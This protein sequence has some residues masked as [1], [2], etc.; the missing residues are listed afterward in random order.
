MKIG[1]VAEGPADVAVISNIL[2]GKLGIEGKDILPI[3]P[4]LS[5]DETDLH[6]RREETFSNWELVKRECVERARIE[7]FLVPFEDERLVVV[8]IDTAEA[9]LRGY[10]VEKPRDRD[11][12][13]AG[14]LRRRVVEAIDR[15]L[16]GRFAG[17]VRHAVAVEETDAWVLTLY[18]T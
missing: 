8:H 3:R 7:A 15:W 4:D 11:G 17:R 9:G 12:D 5:A 10:D 6:E 18:S 16:D 14:A 1:I 13:Y 2:R